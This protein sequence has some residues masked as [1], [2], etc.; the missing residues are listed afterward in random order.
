M[1]IEIRSHPMNAA[2]VERGCY[3]SAA[4]VKAGILVLFIAGEEV[5]AP[6][7]GKSDALAR[8]K[9]N[10]DESSNKRSRLLSCSGF[11]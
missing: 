10:H 8:K 3:S 5:P 9:S 6:E 1:R 2:W 11:M 7:T 4:G